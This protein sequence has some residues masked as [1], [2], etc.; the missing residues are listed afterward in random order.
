MSEISY[1]KL[2]AD[3]A[4]GKYGCCGFP[5]PRPRKL[6]QSSTLPSIAQGEGALPS[7]LILPVEASQ[8]CPNVKQGHSKPMINGSTYN[9]FMFGNFNV[10]PP[11]V[12][13]KLTRAEK[14]QS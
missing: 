7:N 10:K 6:S 14:A 3:P 5:V 4:G 9:F 8:I 12:I 11:G 2:L 13:K 1:E